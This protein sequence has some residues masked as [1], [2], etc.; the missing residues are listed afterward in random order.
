MRQV[1]II[2]NAEMIRLIRRRMKREGLTM[3]AQ[4]RLIGVNYQHFH[5]MLSGR[6]AVTVEVAR[7][8]QFERLNHVFAARHSRTPRRR[9]PARPP[10][11]P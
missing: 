4:A 5:D 2:T 3:V 6:T 11:K 9:Q 7:Y 10:K 1:T 8:F